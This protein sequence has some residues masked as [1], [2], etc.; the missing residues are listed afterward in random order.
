VYKSLQLQHF[1]RL[2]VRL[3]LLLPPSYCKKAGNILQLTL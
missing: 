3:L 2:P 1:Q